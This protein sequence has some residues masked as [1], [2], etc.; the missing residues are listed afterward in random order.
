MKRVFFIHFAF[1]IS[2][3]I[4]FSIFRGWLNFSYWTFWVGG[5]F[6]TI[7]PELDQILYVLFINPQELS[8][9]RVVYLIKNRN[10]LGALR[11][12][13]E[14][15]AERHTLI[16]H[17]N[18]FLAVSGILFVWILTSSGSVLGFGLVLGI[19]LDLLL[20]RLITRVYHKP[21]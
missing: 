4:L 7:I 3:F 10:F 8:S 19:F 1:F 5:V 14:T 13:F 2:V 9:Q 20:D 12:L 17:S 16:F 18:I 21:S 6:G 15:K 11:L